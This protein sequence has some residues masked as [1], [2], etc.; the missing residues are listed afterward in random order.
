MHVK[1]GD[2]KSGVVTEFPSKI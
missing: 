2:V 1:Q